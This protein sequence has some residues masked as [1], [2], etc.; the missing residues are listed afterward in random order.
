M[1]RFWFILPKKNFTDFFLKIHLAER[2]LAERQLA[3]S[4]LTERSFDRKKNCK[5]SFDR[6]Y[7]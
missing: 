3:K 1:K 2:Q 4:G 6:I 5:R 7:I